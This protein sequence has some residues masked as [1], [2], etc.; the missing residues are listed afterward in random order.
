M[1]SVS[2]YGS[3]P[4]V[5]DET[6]QRRNADKNNAARERAREIS[7]AKGLHKKSLPVYMKFA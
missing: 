2:I 1:E 3:G 4:R 6:S 5:H 7:R